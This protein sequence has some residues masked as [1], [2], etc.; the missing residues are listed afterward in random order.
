MR[1]IAFMSFLFAVTLMTS[2]FH[3]DD[4]SSSPSVEPPPVVEDQSAA[5]IYWSIASNFVSEA[6]DHPV[7][8]PVDAIITSAGEA[9]FMF[10]G[11]TD[12]PLMDTQLVG[13][14]NVAADKFTASLKEYSDGNAQTSTVE[15]DGTIATKDGAWGSYTW[16]QDF[17]RFV[18]NY[19]STYEEPSEL[20]KLEGIWTFSQAS[21]SGLT[22]T[23]TL[24]I[25]PD[26]TVFGSTTDGCVFNGKFNI[27]DSQY[28]IYRLFLETSLCG[29]LD[30]SYE[31]LAT[32][33]E[34]LTQR[35]LMFG[36]TNED[37]SLSGMV[38]SPLQP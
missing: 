16:E 36:I 10:F 4:D 29:D 2:C 14:V 25:D 38:Y 7:Q 34:P 31:G 32:L 37:H 17:G 23:L 15:L 12:T 9:R 11:S 6:V 20:S 26:G 18:L 33:D 30:G 35:R 27:I 13:N 19:I 1:S 28:N 24:T 5:G 8:T 3:G 21:S 22:F